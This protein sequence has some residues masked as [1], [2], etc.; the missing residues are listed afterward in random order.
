MGQGL[1]QWKPPPWKFRIQIFSFN[2]EIL[3]YFKSSMN[4]KA[5]LRLKSQKM[6]KIL[7]FCDY[8]N[9]TVT[10]KK[11]KENTLLFP[12]ETQL[13]KLLKA[14]TVPTPLTDAATIQE[15]LFWSPDYHITTLKSYAAVQC[16]ILGKI[17]RYVNFN[18]NPVFKPGT[19]SL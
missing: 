19:F 16:L 3:K 10:M 8:R 17:I 18:E 11:C 2:G 15:L 4:L 5:I 1:A 14:F 6:S 9:C 7:T 13:R 12:Y